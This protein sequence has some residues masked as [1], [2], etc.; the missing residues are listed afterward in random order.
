MFGRCSPQHIHSCTCRSL[1]RRIWG[2]HCF[3]GNKN[4]KKACGFCQSSIRHIAGLGWRHFLLNGGTST[5]MHALENAMLATRYAG[6]RKQAHAQING[7]DCGRF[8]VSS[9][10][11]EFRLGM[12]ADLHKR[13]LCDGTPLAP[14]IE[15]LDTL[16]A[17]WVLVAELLAGIRV[18]EARSWS[19]ILA[20][21]FCLQGLE[22]VGSRLQGKKGKI[23][24]RTVRHLKSKEMVQLMGSSN[25]IRRGGQARNPATTSGLRLQAP[26]FEE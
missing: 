19:D 5:R 6:K 1:F 22:E 18:T 4:G 3:K 15:V 2:C 11:C 26:A 14:I 8:R 13:K 10:Q 20:S 16:R 24:S 7:E 17:A 12:S 25:H 23:R 21:N 9:P